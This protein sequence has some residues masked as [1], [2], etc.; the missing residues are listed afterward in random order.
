MLFRSLPVPSIGVL[1]RLGA[2][3]VFTLFVPIVR[4][5]VKLALFVK[6]KCLFG[7]VGGGAY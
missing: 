4:L 3:I 5:F 7:F 2:I 6:L 1:V